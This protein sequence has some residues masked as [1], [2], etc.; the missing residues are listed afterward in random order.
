MNWNEFNK[1]CR[2]RTDPVGEVNPLPGIVVETV[3][4]G[5]QRQNVLTLQTQHLCD[6]V[7]G[8]YFNSI[9]FWINYYHYIVV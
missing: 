3:A 1:N 2:R 9:E 8:I 7:V 5:Q 4:G 6:L